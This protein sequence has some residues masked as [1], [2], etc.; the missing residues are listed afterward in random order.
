MLVWQGIG[1]PAN[2]PAEMISKIHA[3]LVNVM[4][5]P[6]IRKRFQDLGAVPVCTSP[7]EFSVFVAAENERWAVLL[8]RMGIDRQQR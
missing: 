6:D 2:L 5:L 1:A 4:S 3:G 7:K 8:K